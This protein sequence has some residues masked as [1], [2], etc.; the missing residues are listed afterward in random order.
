MSGC[1]GKIFRGIAEMDTGQEPASR[2][3]KSFSPIPPAVCGVT[4]RPADARVDHV[5]RAEDGVVSRQRFQQD[6][7]SPARV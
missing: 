3:P 4:P 6:A 7:P 2:T 5:N 1:D